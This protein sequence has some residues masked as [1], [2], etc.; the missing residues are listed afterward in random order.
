MWSWS[1]WDGKYEKSCLFRMVKWKASSAW[2]VVD[3]VGLLI[4]PWAACL[5]TSCY[6]KTTNPLWAKSLM[7]SS[8]SVQQNLY[9]YTWIEAGKLPVTGAAVR[10]DCSVSPSSQLLHGLSLMMSISFSWIFIYFSYSNDL[11]PYLIILSVLWVKLSP[12]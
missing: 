1:L 12:Y 4:Q 11:L 9:I 10:T 7:Q 2:C 8:C 3:V 5:Q 6:V